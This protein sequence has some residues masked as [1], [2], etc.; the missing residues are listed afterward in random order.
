MWK[1]T[2]YQCDK[3]KTNKYMDMIKCISRFIFIPRWLPYKYILSIYCLSNSVICIHWTFWW[4]LHVSQSIFAW[5]NIVTS[6]TQEIQ[7]NHILNGFSIGGTYYTF[8]ST[9]PISDHVYNQSPFSN[10]LFHI[11]INMPS[12]IMN[13]NFASFYFYMQL[14]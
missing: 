10:G 11:S 13:F 4:T 3:H 1:K 8:L 9:L 6:I 2:C 14:I 5:H 7:T 12:F